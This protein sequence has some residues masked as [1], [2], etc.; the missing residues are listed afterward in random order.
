MNKSQF[1]DRWEKDL[2]FKSTMET[3]AQFLKN[4]VLVKSDGDVKWSGDLAFKMTS[5]YGV[6]KELIGDILNKMMEDI[7]KEKSI[8]ITR[9]GI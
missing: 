8:L 9:N 6:P 1:I 2:E 7:V 5:Q 4:G 3:T